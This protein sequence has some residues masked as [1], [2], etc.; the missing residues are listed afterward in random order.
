MTIYFQN[1][2]HP[3]DFMPLNKNLTLKDLVKNPYGSSLKN[4]TK[5]RENVKTYIS[6]ISEQ[7]RY[8]RLSIH[9]INLYYFKDA[10][11]IKHRV[12]S[13]LQQDIFWSTVDLQSEQCYITVFVSTKTNNKFSVVLIDIDSETMFKFKLSNN[14]DISEAFIH[15]FHGFFRL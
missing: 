3:D 2:I 6:M 11:S 5:T 13:N 7:E 12:L 9:P 14:R 8:L 1:S 4:K 15:R 10:E